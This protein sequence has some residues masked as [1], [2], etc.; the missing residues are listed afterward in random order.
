MAVDS[1]QAH[2]YDNDTNHYH[3]Q[4]T[5][6]NPSRQGWTLRSCGLAGKWPDTGNAAG[7]PAAPP[8]HN[9]ANLT[10]DVLTGRF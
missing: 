1:A 5:P 10:P 7:S 3:Q 8:G 2:Y 6:F 4:C 9:R